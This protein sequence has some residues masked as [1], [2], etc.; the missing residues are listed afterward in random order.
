MSTNRVHYFVVAGRLNADG[1]IHLDI[2]PD[3]NI[4]SDSP[5]WDEDT[6]EWSRIDDNRDFDRDTV[7]SA[8]LRR[9]LATTEVT[10]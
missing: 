2:D 1:T 8:A 4:P 7:I 3:V 10:A 5:I 6:E 9:R